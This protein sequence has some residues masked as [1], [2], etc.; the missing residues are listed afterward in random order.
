MLRGE[1]PSEGDGERRARLVWPGRLLVRRLPVLLIVGGVAFGVGTPAGYTAAPFFSA[2]PLVAAP[3]FA[4][5]GTA[6]TA[7]AAVFGEIWVVLYRGGAAQD[8]GESA[9]EVA[10][11]LAVALSALGINRLVRSADVRPASLRDVSAAAQRAV[12]PTPPERLAG[13]AIAA[14]YVGA[15]A[16]D[17]SGGD[18]YAV[19]E[20]PHG[21]RLLVGDVRGKGLDAVRTAVIVI[22]AFREAAEQERTLEAVAGRLERALRREGGRRDGVEQTE[23]F[24]T[25]VL[26]EI[27]ANGPSVLR[28]LNRGHPSPL[29]LTPDGGLRELLPGA[30]APPLGLGEMAHRP[31]RPDET[32]FPA[33]ALLL[34]FTDGVT[35]ARDLLG[36]YYNPSGK[37]RGCRFPG[38]DVLVDTVVE[39]VARHTGGASADD[40]ALLAVQR[41]M[42]V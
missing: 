5:R 13:L 33:G 8:H 34:F 28:V 15:R 31:D 42:G 3:L 24:T 4:L 7:L 26:A 30:P 14:R 25:A 35:G 2:A 40:M 23:G 36:R 10:M 16:A 37:L 41:P 38:P 29:L 1:A 9:T 20:T 22:G 6:L 18:L 12:L 27:P 39:D 32:F 21:V 11:V 19:Q 17:R